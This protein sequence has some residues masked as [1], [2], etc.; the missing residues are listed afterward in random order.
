MRK[1]IVAFVSLLAALI[2]WAVVLPLWIHYSGT[3]PRA[4]KPRKTPVAKEF[5]QDSLYQL[6]LWNIAYGEGYD[7]SVVWDWQ[8]QP[9]WNNSE[10]DAELLQAHQQ[11]IHSWLQSQNAQTLMLQRHTSAQNDFGGNK[12]LVQLNYLQGK[13]LLV[14]VFQPW[15]WLGQS[16]G[17]M[18]SA[19]AFGVDSV[20]SWTTDNFLAPTARML[21]VG[22][23]VGP[24]R[25]FWQVQVDFATA[26]TESELKTLATKLLEL[27][28]GGHA[29]LV[30]GQWRMQPTF[31]QANAIP[32]ATMDANLKKMPPAWPKEDWQ[33]FFDPTRPSG[34]VFYTP[35]IPGKTPV[36]QCCFFVCNSK[37]TVKT[38]ET[39]EQ[40][41]AHAPFQP[42]RLTYMIN[43]DQ[44]L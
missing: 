1:Y 26:P 10:T 32:H 23:R 4:E 38:V 36:Q 2:A 12:Q 18:S 9:W 44:N 29:V 39:V 16:P 15:K 33:I 43:S 35:Y 19:T 28:Q 31:A 37:I 11:G 6:L 22:T 30:A 40:Q 41:F 17:W 27:E 25:L 34:R 14:P 3:T 21:A 24:S 5:Q 8:L 20:I 42:V 13:R 7:E